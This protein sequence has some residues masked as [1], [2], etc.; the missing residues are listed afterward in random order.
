MSIGVKPKTPDLAVHLKNTQSL[1]G[2]GKN[3]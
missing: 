2:I 3:A 1:S